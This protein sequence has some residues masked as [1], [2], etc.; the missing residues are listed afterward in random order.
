MATT[1]KIAVHQESG[2]RPPGHP[3]SQPKITVPPS[4]NLATMQTLHGSPAIEAGS[5]LAL[6]FDRTAVARNLSAFTGLDRRL[7]PL[8]EY[9]QFDYWVY[10]HHRNLIQLVVHVKDAAARLDSRHPI[11]QALFLDLAWLYLLTLIRLTE[12][13]RTSETPTAG[14]R[15]TWFGGAVG[16]REKQETAAVACRGARGKLRGSRAELRWRRMH[17]PAL[18][19]RSWPVACASQATMAWKRSGV[20]VP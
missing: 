4:G 14:C 11:H 12:H 5:P 17:V 7:Q 10:E 1:R 9:R 8:L 16:L 6:L 13:L 19:Q 3:S 15:R 18:R 20:R 2:Q